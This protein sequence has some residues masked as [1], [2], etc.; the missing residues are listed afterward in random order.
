MEHHK[1]G[2]TLIE[3]LVV[4]AIIGLL[5]TMLIITLQD[6]RAKARDARRRADIST[7][8]TAMALY[9]HDNTNYPPSGCEESPPGSGRWTCNSMSAVQYW[10]PWLQEYITPPP[11]DP[12][13]HANPN[14]NMYVY[15][16][17]ATDQGG[18]T[19]AYALY[20]MLE[21]GP[22]ENNCNI[23]PTSFIQGEPAVTWST[24][25]PD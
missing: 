22:Q 2:F 8:Q 6:S 21:K 14:Q 3:L 16:T 13:S 24:R 7:L 15:M 19:H 18:R 9:Y 5:S 23:P 25:C 17:D 20:F 12:G 11:R 10:I 1:K 4:I